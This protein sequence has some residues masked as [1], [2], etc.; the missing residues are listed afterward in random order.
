[1]ATTNRWFKTHFSLVTYFQLRG[2]SST[3]STNATLLLGYYLNRSKLKG[4][5]TEQYRYFPISRAEVQYYFGFSL[6]VINRV[7]KVLEE[8]HFISSK[9]SY[10]KKIQRKNIRPNIARV[11]LALSIMDLLFVL[12]PQTVNTPKKYLKK[13]G[14]D[15]STREGLIEFLN[16][17]NKNAT[18]LNNNDHY[19]LIEEINSNMDLCATLAKQDTDLDILKK[20]DNGEI[21]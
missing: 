15:I 14:F 4:S 1:M 12:A 21:D 13:H 8:E 20:E 18:L 19:K 3:T 5:K 16:H 9:R 6:N 17:I 2:H 11:D 7:N 10:V